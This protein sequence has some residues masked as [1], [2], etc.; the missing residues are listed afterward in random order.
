MT[1]IPGAAMHVTQPPPQLPENG[2]GVSRGALRNRLVG[3][4][5]FAAGVAVV[6]HSSSVGVG[7]WRSPGPGMWPAVVG[8]LLCIVSVA[9]ALQRVETLPEQRFRV[10]SFKVLP[11]VV[12]LFVFVWAFS[13]AGLMLPAFALLVL[14]MRGL[15]RV[16]WLTTLVLAA[17]TTLVLQYLFVSVLGVPFPDDLLL[18]GG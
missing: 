7:A 14:W 12:S 9:V 2:G 13:V 5:G 8:V 1:E 17:V 11:G 6:I 15:G 10:E 4:L 3:T 18:G 16:A